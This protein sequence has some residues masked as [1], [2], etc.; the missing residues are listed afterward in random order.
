MKRV[1][2]K[3]AIDAAL[4][5]LAY[6][7]RSIKEIRDKLSEKKHSIEEIAA[8]VE[9]LVACEMLDDE[10][11]A[12]LLAESR[13]RNKHWGPAKIGAELRMKGISDD[14]IKKTVSEIFGADE[15]KAAYSALSDWL[16]KNK[17][18]NP[19]KLREYGSKE[20]I[21]AMRHLAS[22][23]FSSNA[24]IEAVKKIAVEGSD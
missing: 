20:S 19:G 24:A 15:T 22:R 23:G 14:L 10:K 2:T 4:A 3:T 1:K 12:R 6:R 9:R 11:F 13:F 21:R 16:R 5:S 17:K 18:L 8:V 7:P